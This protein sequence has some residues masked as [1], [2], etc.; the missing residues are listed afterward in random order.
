MESMIKLE[1]LC[2][3]ARMPMMKQSCNKKKSRRVNTPER[4]KLTLHIY[5]VVPKNKKKNTLDADRQNASLFYR[6][7]MLGCAT[8]MQHHSSW[9]IG[10]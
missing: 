5:L 10:A 9:E 4:G 1:G 2:F 6:T 3:N 7:Y 8:P